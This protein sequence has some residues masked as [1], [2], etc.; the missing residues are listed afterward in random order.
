MASTTAES[1]LG[2]MPGRIVIP[3]LYLESGEVNPD[4]IRYYRHLHKLSQA[5]L[6]DLL[7]VSKNAVCGWENGHFRPAPDVEVRIYQFVQAT[8]EIMRQHD[9]IVPPSKSFKQLL[10]IDEP[11]ATAISG[12][13]VSRRRVVEIETEVAHLRDENARLKGLVSAQVREIHTLSEAVLQAVE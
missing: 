13:L 3:N 8:A 6:A 12:H 4:A 10:E 9:G 5:Q 2:R 11:L 7:M 1:K